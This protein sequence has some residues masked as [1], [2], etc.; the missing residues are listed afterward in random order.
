MGETKPHTP[1]PFSGGHHS[2]Q[3]VISFR[4]TVFTPIIVQ[5]QE[6]RQTAYNE[7][8]RKPALPISLFGI[9]GR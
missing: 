2:R 9:I 4:R 6:S 8:M 3:M 5:K 7:K 1:I